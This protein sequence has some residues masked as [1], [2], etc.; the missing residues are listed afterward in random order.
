MNKLLNILHKEQVSFDPASV[1]TLRR[2]RGGERAREIIEEVTFHLTDRLGLLSQALAAGDQAL[3]RALAGR[4]AA[5]SEQV[6]LVGFAQV[7]R[8]LGICLERGDAAAAAAVAARLDRMADRSIC[9]LLD[10]ADR[11]AL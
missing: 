10:H 7:A 1:A 11:T 3:A 2:S 5:A 8:D 6:G 9:R 4:L